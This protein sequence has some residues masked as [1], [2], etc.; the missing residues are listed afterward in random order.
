MHAR[1]LRPRGSVAHLADTVHAVSLSPS[2][3]RVGLPRLSVFSR[4]NGRPASPPVN[5]LPLPLPETVHDVR[6]GR[7]AGP[8]P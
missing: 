1:G 4:L 2:V 6:P 5:A 3:N 7:V 8:S